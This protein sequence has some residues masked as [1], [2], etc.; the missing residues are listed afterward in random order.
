MNVFTVAMRLR[1]RGQE[2][3]S[4]VLVHGPAGWGEFSPF[5]E[6]DDRTCVPWLAA[7][8]EAAL[9]GWRDN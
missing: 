1:F 9:H 4:G 8:R 3:R 5:P 6:Y 2:S 7:A